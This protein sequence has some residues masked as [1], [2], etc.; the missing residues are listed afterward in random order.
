MGLISN[1]KTVNQFLSDAVDG[2]K[3]STTI[4]DALK[5]HSGFYLDALGTTVAEAVAPIKFLTCFYEKLTKI[6]DPHELGL[7]ALR[8]AYQNAVI[9]AVKALP[10]PQS[11]RPNSTTFSPSDEPVDFDISLIDWNQLHANDLCKA[12][13]KS[14]DGWA[15]SMGY[16]DDARR[17][18]LFE[19]ERRFRSELT[20]ILSDGKLAE[21]FKPFADYLIHQ[22]ESARRLAALDFHAEHQRHLF[23]DAG[24]FDVEPFSLNDIYVDLE[25]GELTFEDLIKMEE[26]NAQRGGE[27]GAVHFDSPYIEENGGREDLLRTVFRLLKDQKFNGAIIIQGIAGMG[28]ST[29][30]LKLCAELI[31]RKLKPI[32]VRLT[33]LDAEINLLDAISNAIELPKTLP[34]ARPKNL[35]YDGGVFT[36]ECDFEGRRM[37]N[38]VLIL[39]GWDEINTSTAGFKKRF[40]KVL[41]HINKD[42]LQGYLQNVRVIMTGRPSP[43]VSESQKLI[44]SRNTALLTIRPLNPDALHALVTRLQDTNRLQTPEPDAAASFAGLNDEITG[45]I[46]EKYRS[47]FEEYQIDNQLRGAFDV[48]SNPL[49][50]HLAMRVISRQSAN[51][52]RILENT[53][54]LYRHLIDMTC[55]AGTFKSETSQ[56]RL[57]RGLKL[58]TLL[59][60]TAEAITIHG[61]ESI[62]YEELE[63]RLRKRMNRQYDELMDEIGQV[64]EEHPLH[65]LVINYF[66]KAGNKQLGCEFMHKSFREYLFAENVVQILRQY[67]SKAIGENGGNP[68]TPRAKYWA[69]FQESDS[70]YNLSRDLAHALAPQWI[71]PE[72]LGH[73]NGVIDLEM[74]RTYKVDENDTDQVKEEDK[75][76]QFVLEPFARDEWSAARDGLADVWG[77]WAEGVWLR[78]RPRSERNDIKMERPFVDDLIDWA[79]PQNRADLRQLPFVCGLTLDAHLGEA[80][81]IL[82]QQLHAGVARMEDIPKDIW[83]KSASKNDLRPYQT[84]VKV[85]EQQWILFYPDWS[86]SKRTPDNEAAK[87]SYFYE[88]ICRINAAGWNPQNRFGWRRDL[89]L[90]NLSGADL[91]GAGFEIS[92]LSYFQKQAQLDEEQIKQ[93]EVW[94]REHPDAPW[95]QEGYRYWQECDENQRK[96]V[97][98]EAFDYI[99]KVRL[100]KRK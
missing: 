2:F 82:A 25:C 31:K 1:I 30:T 11:R 56:P 3:D 21:R 13:Q 84:S 55:E 60:K 44:L 90:A 51:Y 17:E 81:F 35:L 16:G 67:A 14:L 79:A 8:L 83:R 24:V 48:L 41:D 29:F 12:W 70:R 78:G 75:E 93:V 87:P 74:Q 42:F 32:R 28:K 36:H 7:I 59:W 63:L 95:L 77:W 97:C 71:T 22:D 64:E 10:E 89:S 98:E 34:F 4:L 72:V 80:I 23:E 37:S 91:S 46:V 18:L 6:T 62:D 5:E 53:T 39:D 57:L 92:F 19:V 52:E 27:R 68:L 88:Y 99:E 33:R 100:D 20:N 49:L 85:D 58:R 15:K 50:A 54:T 94:N 43:S 96:I 26:K 61:R 40:D 47:C 76:K 65:S 66:F 86:E 38:Y 45:S 9:R 69:D 73:L